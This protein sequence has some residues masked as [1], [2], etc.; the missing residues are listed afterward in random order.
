MVSVWFTGTLV[1][2][3]HKE[4]MEILSVMWPR[5]ILVLIFSPTTIGNGKRKLWLFVRR[6]WSSEKH[7]VAWRLESMLWEVDYAHNLVV[8]CFFKSEMY[9]APDVFLLNCL[10]SQLEKMVNMWGNLCLLLQVCVRCVLRLFGAFSYTCSCTSLTTS[11]LH[12]FLEECDD[13]IKSG[14]F[15]CLSTDQAYCSIC[16]GVLLPTC[17]QDEGREQSHGVSPIDNITLMVSPLP[18]V[19]VANER[20]IW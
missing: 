7:L 12:L 8:L 18:P 3:L 20:A 10:Y 2:G 6:K 1:S 15:S 14:S 4:E 5:L 19:I 11:I 9:C 16:F 17:H 13:S